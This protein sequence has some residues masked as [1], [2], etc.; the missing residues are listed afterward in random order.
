ME[1]NKNVTTPMKD[2]N[3]KLIVPDAPKKKNKKSFKSLMRSL[4]KSSLTDE[5]RIQKQK[6]YLD[7]TLINLNSDKVIKI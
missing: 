5:Q 3:E 1:N 6:D 4:T 7:N 2:K